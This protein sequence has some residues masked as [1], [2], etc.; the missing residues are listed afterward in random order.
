MNE[1]APPAGQA[2]T[3]GPAVNPPLRLWALDPEDLATVSSHMQ[4]ALLSPVNA[5]WLPKQRRFALAC[6]RLDWIASQDERWMRRES[7]L[8]FDHVLRVE[9][10]GFGAATQVLQLVEIKFAST[11]APEGLID[12]AFKDGETIRLHVEC[13]EACLRDLGEPQ[14]TNVPPMSQRRLPQDR[15]SR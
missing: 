9:R 15:F 6:E 13:V 12:L 10:A 2:E 1:A 7:G 14:S 11:K 8:H 4:D 3:A 5:V